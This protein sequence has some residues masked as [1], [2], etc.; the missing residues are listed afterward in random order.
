MNNETTIK[1][2]YFVSYSHIEIEKHSASC[3]TVRMEQCLFSKR[4]FFL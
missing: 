4:D 1:A 3:F 2:L